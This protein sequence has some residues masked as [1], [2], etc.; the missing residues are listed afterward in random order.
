MKSLFLQI[1]F[2]LALLFATFSQAEPPRAPTDKPNVVVVLLDDAG[3]GDFSHAGNPTIHTP[4]LSKLIQE[5]LY[6]PQFY[7]ASPACT[8]ARYALLTG[9]YPTRSGFGTWV[10]GPNA[11]RHLHPKER[12]LAEVLKSQ[13][14]QTAIFGKWHLGNPNEANHFT[15]QALPLAHGFNEWYGTNVSN[16]Y[17]SG[18]DLI[19]SQPDGQTPVEGYQIIKSDFAG[20]PTSQSQLTRSYFERAFQ[21]IKQNKERP[22]FVYLPLN[23]PHLPVHTAPPFEG[24]SKRG[25]Y[26]DVIEEIDHWMGVL[27][28]ELARLGIDRNTLTIFT[29]DNGPWIRFQDTEEHK[30]YDEARL[31]IGSALP[32]RDGK[33]S[34]W[35]GGV[36]VPGI[37]HWPGQI[38]AETVVT[39]PASTLDI[40]PTV[41]ALSGAKIPAD[42]TLDGRDIRP[43]L[44]KANYPDPVADFGFV[45]T[46][47]PNNRVYGFR[48][49]PWKTHI[50]LYS[51]TGNDYGFKASRTTPLLF[52]VEVD[53]YERIDRSSQ[54]ADIQVQLINHIEAFEQSHKNEGTFWGP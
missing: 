24:R 8:A 41:T 18:V 44:N 47:A 38:L 49:G 15:P 53:P 9:R 28:K 11:K 19:Q 48:K 45:Y 17:N 7:T 42:R 36:R 23:M 33:G 2:L 35:E 4:N 31:L 54:Y 12:T 52:N 39:A 3:Y 32:F 25:R 37:F 20:D 10:L 40:Y 16:D 14:Y 27:R 50:R 30:I 21:F 1:L 26:G 34:T 51:Q 29:S 22:F 5:G 6:F 46:G 13:N 43:Y